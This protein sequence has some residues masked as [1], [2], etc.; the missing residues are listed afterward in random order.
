MNF[1]YI[2]SQLV[3]IDKPAGI[4]SVPGN[5]QQEGAVPAE[6]NLV[7]LIEKE[8]GKVWIVHR[9]DKTTSGVIV[10]ARSAS[11]HRDLCIIFEARQLIKIY[12]AISIGIPPWDTRT[13]RLPLRTNVGHN[14]RTVVDQRKGK[15]SETQF[16][17]IE[18]F[19]SS[20]PEKGYS[21]FSI[22]P[23]TGRTHQIR[24][25]ACAIGF[26]ILGDSI[27]GAPSTDLLSRPALHAAALQFTYGGRSYAFEAAYPEDMNE[28]LQRIRA[29]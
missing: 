9:L 8:V 2:D 4:A 7:S 24:A 21:L 26:P 29:R 17:L 5:W 23:K 1:L 12:H 6:V 11:V 15:L 13:V 14:H 19:T 28:A 25:H 3:V 27:Y 18:R 22:Q 16:D 20:I 10:F